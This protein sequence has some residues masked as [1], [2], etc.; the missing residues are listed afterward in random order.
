MLLGSQDEEEGTSIR[1]SQPT[2]MPGEPWQAL[3]NQPQVLGHCN[4]LMWGVEQV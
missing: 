1:V 3:V 4:P 2:A